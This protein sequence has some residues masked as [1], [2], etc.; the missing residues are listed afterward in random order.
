M[1]VTDYM[2]R[3]FS[4]PWLANAVREKGVLLT[5]RAAFPFF[6]KLARLWW[7]DWTHNVSTRSRVFTESLGVTGPSAAH[8]RAYEATDTTVLPR[9]LEGLRICHS[10]FAF[11]DL[12]AGKGQAL[13]LA[14]EFPFK[15]IVG[16][17]LSQSLCEIGRRNCRTFRSRTQRCKDIGIIC[18]DAAD[19]TFPDEP[20]VIYVFNSFDD[21]VL[22]RVL[23]HLIKS[24]EQRPRGVVLIYHNPQHRNVVEAAGIFE[25]VLTGTDEKDFRKVGYEVFRWAGHD[26]GTVADDCHRFAR[27]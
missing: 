10:D 17:E 5:L 24:V 18:G 6:A 8:A 20:L 19:F 27:L 15:R 7:W 23:A 13:F 11:V 2:H 16:V 22:A 26:V 21:V 9:L 1:D 12:G 3:R 4:Y 25:R 14:A